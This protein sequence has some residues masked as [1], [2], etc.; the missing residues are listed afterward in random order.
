[1]VMVAPRRREELAS[2]KSA[3]L[4]VLFVKVLTP[5][6]EVRRSSYTER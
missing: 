5:K 1:M 3:T 2:V 4:S 6:A